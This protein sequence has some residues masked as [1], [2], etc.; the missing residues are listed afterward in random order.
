MSQSGRPEKT[1]HQD[2][3]AIGARR[4]AEIAIALRWLKRGE[5][6]GQAIVHLRELGKGEEWTGKMTLRR[7]LVSDSGGAL[8][9]RHPCGH[10]PSIIHL[11][12][13][14]RFQRFK[15]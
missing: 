8:R 1:M 12:A 3:K 13:T 10:P 4:R 9:I 15:S 5:E 2:E 11:N 14:K 7:S 6:R